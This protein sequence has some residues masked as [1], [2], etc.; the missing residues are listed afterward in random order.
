M[1]FISISDPLFATN[2]IYRTPHPLVVHLSG[3]FRGTEAPDEMTQ[4]EV[5]RAR[6]DSRIGLR[7]GLSPLMIST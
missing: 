3:N 6:R 5:S 7:L 4:Q 1:H 2:M